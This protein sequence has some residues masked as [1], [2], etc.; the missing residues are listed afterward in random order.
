MRRGVSIFALYRRRRADLALALL[1]ALLAV[2]AGVGLLG[3][4]GWFLA[5][6]A[7]AGAGSDFNLF[8]PSALVRGL[9]FLRIGARYA[10]RLVGHGATLHLLADLR[11]TLFGKLARLT[12]RQLARFRGGDL[13]A[14]L[15]S[16]VDA[17]DTV[18]LFVLAPIAT[19]LL[20]GLAVALV[21]ACSLPLAGLVLLLC[22]L[23]ACLLVPVG[24][25]IASRRS[26]TQAQQSAADLRTA[27]LDA[28]EGHGDIE[29]M[30]ARA[31]VLRHTDRLC[32]LAAQARQSQSRLA[33]H[34]QWVLQ[35]AAGLALLAVLW[36][37]LPAIAAGRVSG[38]YLAGLL[39]AAL[40]VFEVAGPVM[41]GASRLGAA[42]AAARRMSALLGSDPDLQDPAQP[43]AMPESG[44]LAMQGV[45]YAYPQVSGEAE[46]WVLDGVDFTLMPGER[47]AIVGASGAG[48]STL[49]HLL[50]RVEDPGAGEVR[51]GGC[52]LRLCA[53]ADVQ[54]RIALLS[55]DA[56]V[57]LGT[58]RSNLRIGD[59]AAD[60]AALWAALRAARLD[61]F[62]RGLPRGLDSWVGETGAA[63][64]AGQAR[65]LCLARTLLAPASVLLLD[66]PTVGL[67]AETEAAF[68]GDLPQALAGRAAVLVTHAALPRD[69]VH[70]R[71]RLH[72]GRLQALETM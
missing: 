4:S 55:Q 60:D 53:Q 34:G 2:A 10:E 3:V 41:R 26:G 7:L 65:R 52:D 70:R 32:G 46:S 54:R 64:S 39:L 21:V 8:A 38:P 59:A 35:A 58:V 12:P 62:V 29:A 24:L 14:R 44:I 18:F 68:L 15:T 37:G 50:L 6:A 51:F 45:R 72:D 66:E 17:L 61:T 23:A 48:K 33:A 30:G 31:A 27:V 16:D 47:V 57:F 20:G 19:A 63:L 1:L 67:D 9:S 42:R 36:T 28:V 13:V 71:L 11:G 25:A 40:A 43:L 69:A 49:L 22:L 56:P 5:G